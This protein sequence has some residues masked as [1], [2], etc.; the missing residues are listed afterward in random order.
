[1]IN[2]RKNLK[3]QIGIDSFVPLL[4]DKFDTTNQPGAT[5]EMW[6]EASRIGCNVIQEDWIQCGPW[7]S[8]EE[9]DVIG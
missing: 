1:M 2:V 9:N 3:S 5:S 6:R 8:P 7:N 4:T